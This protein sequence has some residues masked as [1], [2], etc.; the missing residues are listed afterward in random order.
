MRKAIEGLRGKRIGFRRMFKMDSETSD[1]KDVMSQIGE[2]LVDL[3]KSSAELEDAIED[4]EKAEKDYEK[5]EKIINGKKPLDEKSY[6]VMRGIM[7]KYGAS[8]PNWGEIPE[9]SREP[10]KEVMKDYIRKHPIDR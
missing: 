3:L 10:L 5:L 2:H 6:G 8:I 7:I 4:Y 1:K 9:W